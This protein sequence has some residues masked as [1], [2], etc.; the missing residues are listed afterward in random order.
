VKDTKLHPDPKNARRRTDRGRKMIE[1]SL[2]E[3]GAFRSIA[4]DADGIIRA[5]NGVAEAAKKLGMKIR[6]VK[7]KS[8]ELIAIQ[9]DDL[10]GKRAERAALFDNRT[11]ELSVWDPDILSGF[12]TDMIKGI[13]E[14][15][16]IQ[17][18]VADITMIDISG[19][20]DTRTMRTVAG[21]RMMVI[22]IG[23]LSELVDYRLTEKLAKQIKKRFASLREFAEW[24]SKSL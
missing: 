15:D 14:I 24:A 8:D 20:E 10:R 5:G 23:K 12:Q 18:L 19:G 4:V 6:I 11:G 1:S 17:N 9:R 7:G 21:K 16:E 3:V 22:S 13:F 2:K